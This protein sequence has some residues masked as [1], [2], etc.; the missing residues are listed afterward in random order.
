M[1]TDTI[2][3]KTDTFTA[4]T[5]P[6]AAPE[7]ARHD[8]PRIQNNVSDTQS[9]WQDTVVIAPS[10][11]EEDSLFAFADSLLATLSAD[12]DTVAETRE[13]IACLPSKNLPNNLSS[14]PVVT[15][16]MLV[17]FLFF[18]YTVTRGW[19][20]ISEMVKDF[21]YLKE[22][23]S[24]FVE[25]TTNRS[26]LNIAFLLVLVGSMSLF[27]YASYDNFFGYIRA[28]PLSHTSYIALISVAI[29]L[30]LSVKVL[31]IKLLGYVFFNKNI[32]SLFIKSYLSIL[33]GYGLCL[34][35]IVLCLIYAPLNF[36]TALV[37]A[38]GMLYL[39]AFFLIF[40]KIKQIF[41]TGVRSF[42]Y[43]LLYLCALEIFPVLIA[44]KMII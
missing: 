5:H 20:I 4:S 15:S 34:F 8:S 39:A 42:L 14:D 26:Y 2:I 38:G 10:V 12:T 16:V 1:P 19:R 37:I 22:R 27:L 29:L 18:C 11:T 43:I 40:Y 30:V 24:I 36:H 6:V 13:E 7:S 3:H 17:L 44:L 33:F 25:P 28:L 35:P 9:L 41:L 23:S 31:I 32:T 21:F